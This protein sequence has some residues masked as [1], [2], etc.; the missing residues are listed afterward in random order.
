MLTVL[1]WPSQLD[2]LGVGIGIQP[3]AEIDG[4]NRSTITGQPYHSRSPY[5]T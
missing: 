4:V 2:S 5:G 3:S 1:Q